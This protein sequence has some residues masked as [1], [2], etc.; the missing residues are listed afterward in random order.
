MTNWNEIREMQDEAGAALGDPRRCRRHPDQ[1]VSSPDGLF[2][3]LCGKCE[4]E[5]DDEG[6]DGPR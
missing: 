5:A 4:C 1:V 3:G 2:D 6:D